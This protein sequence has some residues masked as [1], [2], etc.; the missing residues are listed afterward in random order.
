MDKIELR[1]PSGLSGIGIALWNTCRKQGMSQDAAIE[2]IRQAM[3]EPTMPLALI[4]AHPAHPDAGAVFRK[5]V[6][7]VIDATQSYLP[8]GGIDARECISRV[9]RATD[10]AEVF[11]ALKDQP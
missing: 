1:E 7:A 10:N 6:L 3:A 8:P 5:A 11:A 9:L 2:F 4:P